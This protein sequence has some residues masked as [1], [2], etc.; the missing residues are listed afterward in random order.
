MTFLTTPFVRSFVGF[1]TLFDEL[2]RVSNFK[3]AS[4]PAYNIEKIGDNSY[5]ISIA[6]AGFNEDQLSLEL[7]QNVLTLEAKN[8]P[9]LDDKNYLHKGIATR[10]FSK[11]FR[12]ADN[13]EV[14]SATFSNGMLVIKLSKNVPEKELPITIKINSKTNTLRSV[15]S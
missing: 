15:A 4:Y 8:T 12:L 1:D 7:K 2:E 6:L 3:E 14:G 11:Q 5:E 10:A 13:V 9:S